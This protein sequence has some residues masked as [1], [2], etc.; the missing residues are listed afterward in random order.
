[1]EFENTGINPKKRQADNYVKMYSNSAG[2]RATGNISGGY[3]AGANHPPA[4]S[5]GKKRTRMR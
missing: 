3:Q 1:M 5:K 4:A 2:D